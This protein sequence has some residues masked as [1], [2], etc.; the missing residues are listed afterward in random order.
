MSHRPP[1]MRNPSP[2]P[3]RSRAYFKTP[4]VALRFRRDCMNAGYLHVSDVEPHPAGHMVCWLPHKTLP[5]TTYRQGV[6]NPIY[7]D[8]LPL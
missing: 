4:S 1:P 3:M 7:M 5:P 2:T 6:W 8:R